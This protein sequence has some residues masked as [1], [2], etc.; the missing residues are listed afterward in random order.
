[1]C[2]CVCFVRYRSLRRADRSSREDLPSVV[3]LSVIVK[4]RQSGGPSPLGAV[5][6]WGRK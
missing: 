5:V 6:S 3:G 2:V 4:P 1:M